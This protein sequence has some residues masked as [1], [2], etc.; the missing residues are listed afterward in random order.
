MFCLFK[1]IIIISNNMIVLSVV[2]V[3]AGLTQLSRWKVQNNIQ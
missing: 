3:N 2:C 1:A